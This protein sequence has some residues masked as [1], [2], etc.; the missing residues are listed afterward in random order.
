MATTKPSARVLSLRAKK[1]HKTRL[2]GNKNAGTLA[3][4]RAHHTR[5]ANAA[6]AAK[7]PE[8]KREF[9]ARIAELAKAIKKL[10][11]RA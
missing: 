4:L 6:K 11:V 2:A 10:E 8:T 3:A 7:K 9:T 5:A 1:A